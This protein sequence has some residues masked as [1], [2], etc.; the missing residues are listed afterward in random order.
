MVKFVLSF[1]EKFNF[2]FYAEELCFTG[3]NS[4]LSTIIKVCLTGKH[5]FIE[6]CFTFVM[7]Y[8][9]TIREIHRC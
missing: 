3:P 5:H 9:D 7:S 8:F 2:V 6:F 1:E 4:T